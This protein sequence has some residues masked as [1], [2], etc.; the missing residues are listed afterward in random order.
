MRRPHESSP[1]Y[2]RLKLTG[3]LLNFWKK[4]LD[5][6]LTD[7]QVVWELMNEKSLNVNARQRKKWLPNLWPEKTPIKHD[8]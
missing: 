2:I 3:H 8:T 6:A 1:V 5:N 7:W 4:Q